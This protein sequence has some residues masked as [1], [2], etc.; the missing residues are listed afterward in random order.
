VYSHCFYLC[1][2][3]HSEQYS[4]PM[5]LEARDLRPLGLVPYDT[6]LDPVLTSD[7]Y[8]VYITQA[9]LLGYYILEMY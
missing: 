1:G 9:M 2:D 8:G 6:R 4:A 7:T 3:R 5:D